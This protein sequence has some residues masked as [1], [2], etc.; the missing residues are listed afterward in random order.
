MSAICADKGGLDIDNYVGR[1]FAA[2]CLEL[3]VEYGKKILPANPQIAKDVEKYSKDLE[4]VRD[5]IT[6]SKKPV[7][8]MTLEEFERFIAPG[9]A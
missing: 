4:L 7:Y 5:Q 8:E 3:L 9:G 6:P 1:F 2:D